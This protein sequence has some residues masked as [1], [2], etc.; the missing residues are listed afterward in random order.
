MATNG[1]VSRR[2]VLAFG[3]AATAHAGALLALSLLRP[4]SPAAPPSAVS[5]EVDL[6]LSATPPPPATNEPPSPPDFGARVGRLIARVEPGAAS[7]AKGPLPSPESAALAPEPASSAW[8]FSPFAA[9][10]MDLHAALT[11]DM[12]APP[13]ATSSDQPPRPQTASSTGGLAEG[14]A[15]RDVEMGLGHGG[16]VLS[17]AE[18]A[19]RSSDAPL[20]GGATFDVVVHPDGTVVAR[21]LRSDGPPASDWSSVADALAR[22]VDPQAMRLPAGHGR[23]VVVRIDAKVKLPD[24]REVKSL[25]GLRLGV[26]KSVLQQQLEAKPGAGGEWGT[27]DTD[28]A[29]MGGA[30]GHGHAPQANAGGAAAQG[31]VQRVLPTPELSVSGKVCSAALGVSPAGISLGGGCSLENIGAHATRIVSGRILS[32]AGL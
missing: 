25:H 14:L 23:H 28:T 29:P 26:A 13:P 21:V 30:L 27:G 24:G 10:P 4:P 5:T 3:A 8:S 2:S 15:Q 32:E 22:S 19:A 1:L 12:V 31:I 6:D 7:P 11:P 16:P 9:G 18:I 20:E 17:A